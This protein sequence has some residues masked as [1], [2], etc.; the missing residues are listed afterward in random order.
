MAFFLSISDCCQCIKIKL[1]FLIAIMYP[2]T[3]QNLPV[4]VAFVDSIRFSAYMIMLSV[5]KDSFASIL[6][7]WRPCMSF[8]CLVSLARTSGRILNRS[9]E[10]N[11]SCFTPCVKKIVSLSLLSRILSVGF[12]QGSFHFLLL[13]SR[14][15]LFVTPWTAAHQASLSFTVSRSLLTQFPSIASSLENFFSFFF[16]RN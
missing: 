15:Q 11:H 12:S 8:S 16:V 9:G 3:L 6:P 10:N 14:V 2:E 1:C 13:F 7:I 5:K 4:L